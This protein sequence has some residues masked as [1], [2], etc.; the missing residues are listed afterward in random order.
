MSKRSPFVALLAAAAALTPSRAAAGDTGAALEHFR[1]QH[2][3]AWRASFDGGTGRVEFLHG[4]ALE[5]DARELGARPRND[6]EWFARARQVLE[7]T[8]ELHGVELEHLRDERAL[9][10]PLGQVGSSD[11]WTVRFRQEVG[12]VPVESG[13]VNVLFD[14][15]GRMLS[16]QT[17]ALPQ[18]GELDVAPQLTSAQA[19]QLAAAAF[20]RDVRL[21]PTRVDAPV[22]VIAQVERGE[23]R[24]G[25]LA[26]R[27]EAHWESAGSEPE[28]FVYYLD[29]RGGDVAARENAIH[30]ADISGVVRTRA[31]PGTAPDTG[32]NPTTTQDLAYATVTSG[33]VSVNA[34]ASGAFTLPGVA[35]P[36]L[37]S[38][39]YDGQFNSV[40]NEAGGEHA[41]DFNVANASGNVLLLNPAPSEHINSQANVA[42]GINRMRDWVRSVNPF[43]AT[44]DYVHQ[45]FVNINSSCNAY[46]NGGAINFFIQA[47]GCVNTAYSTVIA[48]E[49][50]HWLNVRYGTGNG[51]DGM[52]EGNADTFAMYLYDDSIVGRNF[53]G[54]GCH[55]RNGLNTRQFC[56]DANPNC[57]GGVHASGEVWMGASWKVRRN[58]NTAL[59]NAAG[60]ATADALF[61]AWMNA[62]N[63]T[64]IRSVIE[65]QWLTLDDDDGFLTN[66]TP[67][68]ASID[69]AFREQGFPG[70]A[71]P[72]IVIT[73]VSSL[74]D[75][76]ASAG[77]YAVAADVLATGSGVLNN[78]R[79][80]H[81]TQTSG[82]VSVPM[83]LV[84]GVTYSA[85]I[86]DAGASARVRYYVEA[87]TAQGATARFPTGG[88]TDPLFFNVGPTQDLFADSFELGL[89]WSVQ[90]ESLAAGAW[91]R[92]DPN[93]TKLYNNA[94]QSEDDNPAG[95]GYRCMF[96]EQGA[97]FALAE[98]SDV[99]GGPTR[100]VS[101]TFDLTGRVAE[102]RYAYW[103]YSSTNDDELVVELSN[104]GGASWN[105]VRTHSLSGSAWRES[106]LDVNSS[107][108][109]GA[110]VRVRF[111][112]ADSGNNS[113]A[114]AALDD[115]RIVA[116]GGA[117]GPP[118]T[119]FCATKINSLLCEPAIAASGTPSAT[120]SL[121]FWI[122]SS[123]LLNQKSGLLFYGYGVNS[124]PL[125]GGTLCCQ[126]PVRRTATQSTGGLTGVS[127]C[128][129]ELLYDMNARIRSGVDPS[130]APGVSVAAQFYY[131]DPQDSFGIG[132]TNAVQFQIAP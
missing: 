126:P 13:A 8:A 71:L 37:V 115:V 129:G 63:Q 9:F 98:L 55:I 33:A 124:A 29:A 43:D 92:G 117:G 128:S 34:D 35:A 31:T 83:T 73:A 82:F 19:R 50:G 86:P 6:A 62:Y 90:N 112:V 44:A 21:A 120:S 3:P 23:R 113:V 81:G 95:V 51:G 77:P 132:L 75:V 125:Q 67:N 46:F 122:G 30:H 36:A 91:T 88:A 47:G 2:G 57:H 93:G 103:M 32:S 114:E 16:I 66:G 5:L 110:A 105:V 22:L 12:G 60:D 15:R 72:P 10:L 45:S 20:A 78:V 101:P 123:E 39:S 121:P 69:N 7:L 25:V 99:D 17:H 104:N 49:D 118:P 107:F 40:D 131:R 53:C 106:K 52:G 109:P 4:G 27:V 24:V 100:L 18:L 97:I 48:H 56:G 85:S 84:A 70:V 28:G 108:T 87:T 65:S 38:V 74:P 58:L 94:A 54:S 96:T 130:L 111:S 26:W 14:A 127:D 80:F 11:K 64:Q 68:F 116:L 61:L 1:A 119:V 102:L 79:L 76:G 41:L 59:G 89:G 42:V